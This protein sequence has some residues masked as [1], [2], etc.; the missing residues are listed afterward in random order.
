MTATAHPTRNSAVR[1]ASSAVEHSLHTGGV[2][3]SIP[4]PPTISTKLP[5]NEPRY[6]AQDQPLCVGLRA[7]RFLN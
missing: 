5:R 4:V 3:G 6:P 1:A 2:T 7:P